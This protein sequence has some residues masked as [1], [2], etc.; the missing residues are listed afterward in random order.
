MTTV[1]VY[2]AA[3][4]WSKLVDKQVSACCLQLS[5]I[6]RS[7]VEETSR[8]LGCTSCDCRPLSNRRLQVHRAFQV[9]PKT[10]VTTLRPY[11]P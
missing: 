4:H 7:G 6:S 8:D 1:I 2:C 9:I 11:L 10:H 5:Q 3:Q